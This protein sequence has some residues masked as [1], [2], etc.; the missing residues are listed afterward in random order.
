MNYHA[1]LKYI[2]LFVVGGFLSWMLLQG[3]AWYVTHRSMK[4]ID[5]LPY[6]GKF[7]LFST[8][9]FVVLVGGIFAIASILESST[10]GTLPYL[11]ETGMAILVAIFMII[12]GYFAVVSYAVPIKKTYLVAWRGIKTVGLYYFAMVAASAAFLVL[13]TWLFTLHWAALLFFA[14]F[15]LLPSFTVYRVTLIRLARK[16]SIK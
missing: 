6:M 16:I 7:T 11:G 1:V 9:W 10:F 14:L 2:A 12:L 8:L 15:I 5:F 4:K 3:I 13:G